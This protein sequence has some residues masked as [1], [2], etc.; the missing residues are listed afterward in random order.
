[1]T[2]RILVQPGH[3]I[4]GDWID[5]ALPDNIEIAAGAYV[6]SA[7]AFMTFRSQRRPGL[8]MKEGSGSYGSTAFTVGPKGQVRIGA[9]TCLNGGEI[10]CEDRVEIGAHGLISWGVV[11]T[12]CWG[13]AQARPGARRAALR[14]AA[15]RA[16]RWI[17]PVA[18]PRPV[19][20][21]DNVWIGFDAIILPGVR[22]G[23]GCVI[24]SRSVVD[25][26]IPAYA[27]AIGDPARIVRRLEP[28]DTP[29][30]RRRA[31]ETCLAS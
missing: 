23:R 7:S 24:G 25:R 26:D 18:Q 14:A 21:E 12:D 8:M 30:A 5:R 9:F 2:S 13:A 17:P 19:T 27:V 11:I 4:K 1:M 10:I 3:R 6:E 22:L 15:A 31:L 20:I 28:D 16:D 29:E